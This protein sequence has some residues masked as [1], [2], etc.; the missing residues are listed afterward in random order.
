MIN[1]FLA[2]GICVGVVM[3]IYGLFSGMAAGMADAP[4]AGDGDFALWV[5]GIGWFVFWGGV[6]GA[7]VNNNHVYAGLWVGGIAAI[8]EIAF[9]IFIFVNA[10]QMSHH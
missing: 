5:F 7:L 8:V 4:S 10:Y 2:I 1:A 6:S 3:L 9:A